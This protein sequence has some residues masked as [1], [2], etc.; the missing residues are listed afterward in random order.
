MAIEEWMETFREK[1]DAAAIILNDH[2]WVEDQW[3]LQGFAD[4]LVGGMYD[5][6]TAGDVDYGRYYRKGYRAAQ[7]LL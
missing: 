3:I 7:E 5:K 1:I 4:G 2:G 6:E